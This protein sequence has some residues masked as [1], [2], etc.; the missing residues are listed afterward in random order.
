MSEGFLLSIGA[1]AEQ[2]AALYQIKRQLK[3]DYSL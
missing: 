2:A 3:R 1:F